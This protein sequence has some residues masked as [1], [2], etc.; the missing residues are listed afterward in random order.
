MKIEKN[1]PPTWEQLSQSEQA[2]CYDHVEMMYERGYLVPSSHESFYDQ[3][4]K[5]AKAYYNSTIKHLVE[6][7]S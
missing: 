7:K 2:K 4:E 1:L 6:K 3:L 5:A